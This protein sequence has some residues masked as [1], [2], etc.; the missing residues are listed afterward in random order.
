M[1]AS[2]LILLSL[3]IMVCYDTIVSLVK[4][5]EGYAMSASGHIALKSSTAFSDLHKSYITVADSLLDVAW[6]FKASSMF[7]LL[8]TFNYITTENGSVHASFMGSWEFRAYRIYSILSMFAYGL[9]Q[10]VFSYNPL[11]TAV[12][13]QFVYHTECFLIFWLLLLTNYRI[14]RLTRTLTNPTTIA[15][16]QLYVTFNAYLAF[17]LLLD[18]TGLFIINT[19]ILVGH[20]DVQN[21]KVSKERTGT[22]KHADR[23]GRER[24]LVHRSHSSFV[25]VV[26]RFFLFAVCVCV[27]SSGLTF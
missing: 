7:M 3:G 27:L 4:Y 22:H 16:M 8:A 2:C 18:F 26:L 12:V 13:P 1:V 9:L 23:R 20:K 11:L 10:G 21:S 6:S 14:T 19:D 15:R 5:E 25:S 24:A 17:S